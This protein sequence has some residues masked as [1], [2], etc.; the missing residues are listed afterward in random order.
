MSAPIPAT[1]PGLLRPGTG[2]RH[3]RYGVLVVVGPSGDGSGRYD[4]AASDS[5]YSLDPDTLTLDLDSPTSRA[6]LWR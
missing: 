3:D 2:V 4:C 1:L 5:G 6:H